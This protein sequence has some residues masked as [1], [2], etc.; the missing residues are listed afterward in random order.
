MKPFNLCLAKQGRPVCTRNGLPVRIICFNK[1][2]DKYP[3]VGLVKDSTGE[4][5][6]QTDKYGRLKGDK[7]ENNLD[8][9]MVANEVGWINIYCVD[10]H[11]TCN[12]RPYKTKEEALTDAD[13]D[14]IATIKVEW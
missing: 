9:M 12:L 14:C 5:L 1:K 8:L 2:D 4:I 13:R 10:K 3:I 6:I 11:F 7:G